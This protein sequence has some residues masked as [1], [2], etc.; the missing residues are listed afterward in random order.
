MPTADGAGQRS[1][2]QAPLKRGHLKP[3]HLRTSHRNKIEMSG[4]SS[5]QQ[6][7]GSRRE[8]PFYRDVAEDQLYVVRHRPIPCTSTNPESHAQPQAGP[9]RGT[10]LALPPFPPERIATMAPLVRALRRITDAGFEVLRFD[11]RGVGESS[12]AAADFGFESLTE[13]ARFVASLAASSPLVFSACG[14][15]CLAAAELFAEGLGDAML[16]WGPPRDGQQVMEDALRLRVATDLT[17]HVDSMGPRRT[18]EDFLAELE[19]GRDLEV[20]GHVISPALWRQLRER[21]LKLP[22]NDEARPWHAIQLER[23]KPSEAQLAEAH[24]ARIPVPRP[25]FWARSPLLNPDLS[26][27]LDASLAWLDQVPGAAALEEQNP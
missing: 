17:V 2:R 8:E 11:P 23:A 16:L 6:E 21:S 26:P 14:A 13:D 5:S 27:L 9:L 12:G 15:G 18:S 22:A 24:S 20:E 10:V 7:L 4:P 3:G 1:E 19:D 25:P